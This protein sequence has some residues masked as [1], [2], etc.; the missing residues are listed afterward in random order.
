MLVV[1]IELH[2]A[3]TGKVTEIGRMTITNDGYSRRCRPE[4]GVHGTSSRCAGE[5]SAKT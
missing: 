1:R 3:V 2:S 4:P 5:S